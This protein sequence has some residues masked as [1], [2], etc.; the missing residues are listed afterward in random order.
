MSF[1]WGFA[2]LG[3]WGKLEIAKMFSVHMPGK[4]LS[5]K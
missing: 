3:V 1:K 4:H 5:D 2:L